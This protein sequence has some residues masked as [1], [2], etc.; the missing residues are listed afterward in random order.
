MALYTVLTCKRKLLCI[1]T[2]LPIHRLHFL[3]LHMV[4]S[5]YTWRFSPFSCQVHWRNL[6]EIPSYTFRCVKGNPLAIQFHPTRMHLAADWMRLHD[7]NFIIPNTTESR[8]VAVS[9]G[10]V[11]VTSSGGS[12]QW[13]SILGICLHGPSIF[14]GGSLHWTSIGRFLRRKLTVAKYTE[15]CLQ[16]PSIFP[17]NSLNWL[18]I[19]RF[20]K[21]KLTPA[22]YTG[23]CLHHEKYFPG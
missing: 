1:F 2:W 6:Q 9:T 23:L 5:P 11:L 21:R 19:G 17:G 14:P 22:K 15:V 8:L 20:L 10:Q 18:S 12:L 7:K 13:P 16:R 3:N 4:G